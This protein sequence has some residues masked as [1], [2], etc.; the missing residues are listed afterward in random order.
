[1]CTDRKDVCCILQKVEVSKQ[2]SVFTICGDACPLSCVCAEACFTSWPNAQRPLCCRAEKYFKAAWQYL[3]SDW[4]ER[5]LWGSRIVARGS[6][7]QSRGQTVFVM[8]LV[9]CI[10]SLFEC[11]MCFLLSS[12]P[13]R[14]ISYFY[15]TI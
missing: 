3:P 8:F 12:G 13:T 4:L 9:Y 6:S 10:V 14:Y 7:P 2:A 11:M 15:G 5:L 1:M